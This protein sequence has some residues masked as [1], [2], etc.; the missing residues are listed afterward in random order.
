MATYLDTVG[1]VVVSVRASH[2]CSNHI[3]DF[4]LSYTFPALLMLQEPLLVVAAFL[5][6]FVL[7]SP[8][9]GAKEWRETREVLDVMTLV[10]KF[11][12]IHSLCYFSLLLK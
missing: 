3:Q 2:L 7:V 12:I 6:L 10:Y 1:R 4:T 11:F 5:A 8:S 9:V